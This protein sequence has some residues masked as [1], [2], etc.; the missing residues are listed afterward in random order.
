[1]LIALAGIVCGDVALH[2]AAPKRLVA[3]YL[4]SDRTKTPPYSA[5]NI[6]FKKLTHLIH[7]AAVV[8][9]AG[10]GS[11][12][13]LKDAVEPELVPKAHAAKVR[14]LL[15][16]QGPSKIFKKIAE[17][18]ESRLKFAKALKEFVQKNEYDGVDIDWEVPLGTVEVANNV[19]MM[20][21][22]REA[23]PAPRY[24]LSMA[25][26]AAPGPGR[27]GEFDFKALLPIVDFFNVMT[28]DFHGPWTMHTGHN[29]PLF[30][31]GN[32]QGHEGSIDESMNLYLNQLGV[33]PDKINLGTAFY[34]Y[35][36]PAADLN[37]LCNCEKTTFSREYGSYIKMRASSR[38]WTAHVDGQAMAP[39]LVG[40]S[41]PP[42]FLTYDDVES[43][44]RKVIYAFEVRDL[45]G[46][47]MWE[48]S[49]DFDG[50]K[51]DLLDA[52]FS[53]KKQAQKHN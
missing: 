42:T 14:V 23:L 1:M 10:D 12:D 45:G 38:D 50:K 43:T 5:K 52:M 3:Y 40:T 46:V 19:A 11:I 18:P 47:F 53:I 25:T 32:D 29:S 44:K 16:V 39:Y 36:S 35:E 27:W 28:Y 21:A 33:P 9:A 13:L 17:Q 26:T 34:G 2:A 24:L 7:V 30:P 48:L 22:L 6:P 49:G 41:G 37:A 31:S 8:D 20:Q 4:Y 51:Q 15:C